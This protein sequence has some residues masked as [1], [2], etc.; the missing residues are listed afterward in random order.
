MNHKNNKNSCHDAENMP[1]FEINHTGS[2]AA[3]WKYDSITE[4]VYL[5]PSH[6]TILR[7]K[8]I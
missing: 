5:L 8:N 3:H 1:L 6:I 4:K 2:I 7:L